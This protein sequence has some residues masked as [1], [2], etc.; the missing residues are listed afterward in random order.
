MGKM[1]LNPRYNL[2]SVRISDEEQAE[3]DAIKREGM[4]TSDLLR[5]A[6]RLYILHQAAKSMSEV[7]G[8]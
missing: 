1:K 5:D 2:I 7:A 3:L 8:V 6:L 4:N